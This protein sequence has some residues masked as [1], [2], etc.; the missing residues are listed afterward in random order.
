MDKKREWLTTT[1]EEKGYNK[2]RNELA[3]KIEVHESYIGK[4]ESGQRNPSVPTAMKLGRV[5]GIEWTR[6]FEE[7]QRGV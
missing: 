4:I 6:F 1:I 3:K 5:L 2:R 7:Q